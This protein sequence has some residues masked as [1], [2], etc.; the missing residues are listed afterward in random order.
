MRITVYVNIAAAILE[1]TRRG[2][3]NPQ[4]VILSN[5]IIL[6]ILRTNVATITDPG[7]RIISILIHLTMSIPTHRSSRHNTSTWT[8]QTM[9]MEHGHP[10]KPSKRVKKDE[11]TMEVESVRKSDTSKDGLEDN[12]LYPQNVPC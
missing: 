6:I 2:I 1:V 9:S 7:S 12:I 11:K 3:R 4:L 5:A 10:H 8:L